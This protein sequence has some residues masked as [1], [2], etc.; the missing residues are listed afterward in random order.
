MLNLN[1][2]TSRE[3][4]LLLMQTSLITVVE[5]SIGFSQATVGPNVTFD[6]AELCV[7]AEVESPFIDFSSVIFEGAISFDGTKF[8]VPPQFHS[9]EL[10]DDITFGSIDHFPPSEYKPHHL[11]AEN[12][13]QEIQTAARHVRDWRTLKRK[14]NEIHSRTD[15]MRFFTLELDARTVL[16]KLIRHA[17]RLKIIG[18]QYRNIDLAL[19]SPANNF[20]QSTQLPIQ[21]D[22]TK[23]QRWRHDL[24]GFI[25]GRPMQWILCIFLAFLG[26]ALVFGL[27]YVYLDSGISTS[28]LTSAKIIAP[29]A[30]VALTIWYC[31]NWGGAEFVLYRLTSLYGD[32]IRRPTL[33]LLATIVIGW[34]FYAYHLQ[35]PEPVYHCEHTRTASKCE[36]LGVSLNDNH[37]VNPLLFSV[38][39]SLIFAP[40]SKYRTNAIKEHF[41]P[42]W[43]IVY[44]FGLVQTAISTLWL[45]LMGL[46]VR[47]RYF[48]R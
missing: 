3:P 22:S 17:K 11:T 21:S 36:R 40:I 48:M 35:S 34:P 42:N 19:V 7:R 33:A 26:I 27:H 4:V 16:R 24:W 39:Q 23:T 43:T 2:L 25:Y 28:W 15:E 12:I 45:F 32:S 37:A 18:D 41:K 8:G 46:G 20:D 31:I 1:G 10:H 13:H 14:M 29:A 5:E 30:L 44:F 9:A 38:S 6:N 47:N